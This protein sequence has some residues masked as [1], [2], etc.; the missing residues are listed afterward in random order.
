VEVEPTQSGIA[1][2]LKR[3]ASLREK[4]ARIEAERDRKI[5]PKRARFE[6]AC[7]PIFEKANADLKP[8]EE[9]L[10]AIEQEITRAFMAGVDERGDVKINRVATATAIAEVVTREE[11]EIDPRRFFES[12]P[13]AQRNEAFWSCL[14]T[15]VGRA[16]KFLGAQ[17]LKEFAHAKRTHRVSIHE[18]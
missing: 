4:K 3:W 5:A 11:R 14:K 2:A 12:V 7:A 18:L 17:R 15:L 1:K 9:Q 10:N 16:E 8:V 13:A 6:Q